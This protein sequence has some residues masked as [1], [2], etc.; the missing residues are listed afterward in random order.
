ML[1][2]LKIKRK[3][4]IFFDL[5]LHHKFQQEQK[6]KKN[7]I[8]KCDFKTYIDSVKVTVVLL[9]E[10]TKIKENWHYSKIILIF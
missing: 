9:W 1:F 8:L 6:D 5:W 4:L 7:V 2:R 3:Y 10:K